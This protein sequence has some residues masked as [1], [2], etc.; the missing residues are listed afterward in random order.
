[1]SAHIT[2]NRRLDVAFIH[3][4]LGIGGAERLVVDAAM[5]IKNMKNDSGKENVV[6]VL[7]SHCDP[8]HCFEEVRNGELKVYVYG[9]FLPTNLFGMF[10]IVFAFLRQLYL[11]LLLI[12][13]GKLNN[14]DVI[15]VDQ[16]AYCIP[17]LHFYKRPEAKI[18]FYC[19]FPDKLLAS[20]HGVLRSLYRYV[21]DGIEEWT[22]RSA[23]IIVVNSEFT[24]Q[25]VLKQFKSIAKEKRPLNV[26]YPCVPS[27]VDIDERSISRVSSFFGKSSFFLSVNRFERKKHIELAIDSYDL[28]L[29]LEGADTKERLVISGGYDERVSENKTYLEDLKSKCED[30]G[31]SYAITTLALEEDELGDSQVIFMPSI[32]TD[33]K[34]AL[35][36]RTDLLMYTPSYEHFGIVPVEAMRMGKLVL[37]DNTGGP[38]E[39]VVNYSSNKDSYTGFTVKA[40]AQEWSKTLFFVKSLPETEL[41]TVSNRCVARAESTFSFSAMQKALAR[42]IDTSEPK[43]YHHEKVAPYFAI[44][45]VTLLVA[46]GI[47]MKS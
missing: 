35:L 27:R 24:K 21:F 32:A 44:S 10:S 18:I 28:Y 39:T 46:A 2:S 19:H 4:D 20:H 41:E 26:V 3:P 34:N 36:S 31:L 17:L 42:A 16:L 8:N 38:L 47:I 11:V 33:I 43:V 9:D 13:T 30:L 37:A 45:F 6:K 14:Y 5:A 23:D 40:D 1:M 29:K 25:T 22:T 12:F 7:T 15:F